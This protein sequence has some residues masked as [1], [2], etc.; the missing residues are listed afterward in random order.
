LK[1]SAHAII[2]T[3]V[4]GIITLF[5]KSA[6]KMLG[7]SAAEVILKETPLK[8]HK[9]DEVIEKAEQLNKEFDIKLKP[10][11]SVFI[12]RT[13][14]DLL[15]QDEW[16]Y[17]NKDNQEIIVKLSVTKLIDHNNV[18][19]GYLGIAE[20]ITSIKNDEV[21]LKK[22]LELINQ[23]IITSSTDL[24][25]NITYTSEA[26]CKISGYT[27]DELIGK[28]HNIVRHPDMSDNIYSDLWANLS[29][30]KIWSGEIKNLKKDGTSYWVKAHIYPIYD[31]NGNKIGYTAIRQDITDKKLI[32][33][34][35]ITD[36]LTDIFNRRHFDDIFPNILKTNIRSKEYISFLMMDVDHFKQ[37][38]DTYGHQMGDDVLINIAK[39]L[40][41]SLKRKD[42]LC[43]RLGGEEFGLV[44]YTKD[45]KEAF[46]YA[47]TIK[48]NLENLKIEHS[49]NSVSK[50]VTASMGLICIKPYQVENEDIIY[51]EAD[52]LLYQAKEQGRNKV[53]MKDML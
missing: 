30:D 5:N 43:F 12:E 2:A 15:N 40:K 31:F 26:F 48:E 3:D 19:T 22:Y 18:T 46:D 36:G 7:Y 24:K 21:Q 4:D 11:F 42:D 23:N 39:T 35:S 13:N 8:F 37:Y 29:K 49:G 16:T 47:I 45:K 51:R 6:E 32:E 44:F 52:Q 10:S 14:R 9:V 27:K 25:G 50:Y 53:I 20:D 17:I 41:K 33:I 1:H 38:N 28:N 34:I